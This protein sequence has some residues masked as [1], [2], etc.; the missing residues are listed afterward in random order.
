MK[1]APGSLDNQS[2]KKDF[3]IS[4][5]LGIIIAIIIIACFLAVTIGLA[6]GLKS[7]YK[8]DC[9]KQSDTQKFQICQDLSCRN[10]SILESQCLFPSFLYCFFSKSFCTLKI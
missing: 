6:V 8:T 1:V 2:T 4:R 3:E 7:A 9:T 10:I 5:T